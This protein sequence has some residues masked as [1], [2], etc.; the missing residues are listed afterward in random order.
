MPM[1]RVKECKT[2]HT[3]HE[4]LFD[5]FDLK[6]MRRIKKLTKMTIKAFAEAGDD[7]DPDALTA[8]LK[9]LHERIGVEIPMDDINLDF[10]NFSMEP[11]EDELAEME[12]QGLLD[13][14][15]EKLGQLPKE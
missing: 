15:A 14:T 2:C 1:I 10:K 7:G 11:T 9:I 3:D 6:E 4:W 5:G 8:M 13:E 12:A